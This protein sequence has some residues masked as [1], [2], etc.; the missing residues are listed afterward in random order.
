VLR[1]VIQMMAKPAND[2]INAVWVIYGSIR[3]RKTLIMK[4]AKIKPM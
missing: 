2:Q 1:T 3:V 4:A